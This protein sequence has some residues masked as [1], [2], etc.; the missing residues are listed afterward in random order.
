M[1]YL[2]LDYSQFKSYTP[3]GARDIPELMNLSGGR[4][5]AYALMALLNGGFRNEH[6]KILFENTGKENESCLKF[7]DQ[8]EKAI[9][10]PIVQIE[11]TLTKKF[12]EELVWSSFSYDKFNNNEYTNISQILNIKKLS[13]YVF[14]K[15]PNN[16]WYK[17]KFSDSTSNFKVVDYSTASRNGKPFI[18]LFLYKCAIRMMKKEGF[19]LPNAGQRWCTGDMKEKTA[20]NY[21]KSL[22]ITEYVSYV[23]MRADEEIRVDRVHRKNDKGGSIIY[24]CPLNWL[25]VTKMDTLTAWAVQPFDLGRPWGFFNCFNDVL[26]NC[27]HCHLKAKIKKLYQIQQGN[28]PLMWMQMESLAENYNGERDCMNRTHGTYEELVA[29][30]KTIPPITLQEVMSDEEKEITCFGCGD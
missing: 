27:D 3:S 4:S 26:G 5:S 30:A 21:M 17:E 14:V 9:D 19:V 22:G 12:T 29:H 15:S 6:N 1:K 7:I 23:G 16:F 10:M 20:N 24:D 11:Y 13:E 28:M 2:S 18:D 25:G 8:L